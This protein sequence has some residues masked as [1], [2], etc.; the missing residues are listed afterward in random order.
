VRKGLA[1]QKFVW[2]GKP[3]KRI[4]D[5]RL[6]M[7]RG[8]FM[9][10]LRLGPMLHLAILRSP[11]AHARIL[12][13]DASKALKQ[14]G[15]VTVLTG[16]DVAK[17][18]K[19]FAVGVLNPPK[20]Y[21]MA[22]N[23]VR[24][25]GE[26]VAAVVAKDR[27]IAED[28]L[29]LIDVEY[30]PLPAVVDAEK[31]MRSDAP[32]LHEELGT[33]VAW[34][35]TL[36]YGNVDAAFS[37]ADQIIKLKLR[38]PRYT[39]AP[40]E[41]YGVIARYDESTGELTIWSNFQ[42]PWTMYAI[43]ASSLNISEEKVRHIVPPDI[44]GGFG[45]KSSMYPYLVL[46]ALAAMKAKATVKWIETRREHLMASSTHP[47]RIQY[48]E[49]AIKNDGTVLGIKTTLIDNIGAYIRAPEPCSILR[50]LGNFV[51]PYRFQ[52]LLIDANSVHTN[53]CPT[54]P[55]RGLGCPQLFFGWERL[56]DTIADTLGMDPAEVRFRNLIQ[57]EQMPYTTPTG[58]IYD[59]G[60]YPRALRLALDMIE[61][62][63]IREEQRKA[64]K[65]GRFIGVGIGIGV[66][67]AVSNMGYV[68]VAIPPEVRAR[69]DYLPK[70][71]SRNRARVKM[72]SSGKVVVS[73]DVN[74]QGQGHE[75]TI[76]Q[77]VA[78]ELG[79]KPEDVVVECSMDSREFWTVSSGTYSSRFAASQAS[80]VAL[81]ARK[82][83]EKIL[84][85]AA[86]LLDARVEDLE[87]KE[88]YVRV[89]DEP[90]RAIPLRR[91]AGVVY[92]NPSQLPR[93]IEPILEAT[94]TFD[95][96][97]LRPPDEND[98][99]NSSGTYGF[100]ADVAKVEVDIE[101]GVVNVL[102]FVS[103]HD[104]GRVLNPMIVEGQVH[105]SVMHGLAGALYEELFYNEEGQLLTAT[106]EDYLCPTARE[107][108]KDI[109]V[110]H[111][112]SPSPYTVLGAKGVAEASSE[113][114]PVSIANAVEDALKPLG[115]KIRELPLTPDKVWRLI[116]EAKKSL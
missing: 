93:E 31:A 44:G 9:D 104:V 71:G 2:I 12:K 10:N 84:Q 68:T 59:S 27:Y 111:I 1:E 56:M 90:S 41:G 48:I 55:N 43:A 20:Y 53:K 72:A 18:T 11:Y 63:K 33:N 65:E 64:W 101:T 83:K 30:E 54:G 57:P 100:V 37:Q 21:C 70:S 79:V 36:R 91:V 42:G 14:A 19:P 45:I 34:H 86:Y 15:V 6:L 114:T 60:D 78:E 13:I 61:Y 94:A 105:G 109:E 47:D 49:A 58:G 40:L 76:A 85:I 95:I 116:K 5:R 24:Y 73:V 39:S 52:N 23:K 16:E 50:T 75:T 69:K 97:T 82:L 103:V 22:V 74:P 51:G 108:L 96:P 7:G 38:F 102:K 29:E 110:A 106:F 112:E 8:R 77:I 98:R 88:G 25:V 87:L 92:W 113:T 32:L 3:V 28:A 80:A 81:A 35:R 107:A 67:P 17:M 62:D 4:E 46:V 89:K 66:D 115:V 99:L 26:P